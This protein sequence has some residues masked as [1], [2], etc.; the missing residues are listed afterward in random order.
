MEATHILLLTGIGLFVGFIGTLIGAGGGFILVPVLLLLFPK[1]KPEVI[2]SIS[3]AVVFL[4]AASGSLAYAKMKRVDYR[5]AITFAIA[6]LPGAVLG[7]FSTSLIPQRVFDL[8]LGFVLIILST[9]QSMTIKDSSFN[10][11]LISE[12]GLF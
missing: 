9:V 1:L 11:L 3:L 12:Q 6:A 5:S 4:N 7:A 10:I 2:T 8:L